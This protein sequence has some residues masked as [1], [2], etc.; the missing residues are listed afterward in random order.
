MAHAD[1]VTRLVCG[2]LAG[3]SASG[4]QPDGADTR[5][6]A[7]VEQLDAGSYAE[8]TRATGLLSD[9]SVGADIETLARARVGA[10]AEARARL[11]R[12]ILSLFA[13]EPK[14][15]L[16]V[17]FAPER[18]GG[19]E[20]GTV[21][22]DKAGFPA[23]AMLK[24]GD[25]IVGADGHALEDS[26]DLRVHILSHRPGE[27]LE[28][29]VRRGGETLR[30]EA[31]LGAYSGLRGAAPI[32]RSIARRAI[33]AAS[34]AQGDRD[35]RARPD[36]GRDRDRRL[37]RRGV[38]RGGVRGRAPAGDRGSP[39]SAR[40]ARGVMSPRGWARRAGR[41]CDPWD[42]REDASRILRQSERERL[43][44]RVRALETRI[45][46]LEARA[47]ALGGDDDDAGLGLERLRAEIGTLRR[48]LDRARERLER[49]TEPAGG[50]RGDAP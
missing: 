33:L 18:D 30:F 27:S 31:P 11:D 14:G 16:G 29:T 6:A 44:R 23:A 4:R 8:R 20:I 24:P 21:V 48:E 36:R 12:A 1:R 7:L 2:A 47:G 38:P 43:G 13:Q 22:D 46:V 42:S 40:A 32:E 25:L 41:W 35:T 5:V 26:D 28:L 34:G 37:A 9:A 50:E 15:G 19:V 3:A 45:R 17:G 39:T 10:S 49:M